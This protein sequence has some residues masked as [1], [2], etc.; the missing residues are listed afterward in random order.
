MKHFIISLSLLLSLGFSSFANTN[1]LE[2]PTEASSAKLV[3][4]INNAEASDYKTYTKAAMFAINWNADL[5]LAKEW[6]DHALSV[7]ENSQTVEVL[8]DYYV[9]TGQVEKAKA[10]YF[11][12]LE[13]GLFSVDQEDINRMQRK[14]LVYARPQK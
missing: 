4:M 12:A 7:K 8:G 6:I 3:N 2:V 1:E 11:K 9:R 5:A 10:A 13:L 14:V